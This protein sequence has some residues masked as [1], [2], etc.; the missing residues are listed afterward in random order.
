MKNTLFGH[1]TFSVTPTKAS[2]TQNNKLTYN[3]YF[4]RFLPYLA[5]LGCL[6][7]KILACILDWPVQS[8]ITLCNNNATFIFN[9]VI[10]SY[11]CCSE[12]LPPLFFSF[13]LKHNSLGRRCQIESIITVVRFKSSE[14]RKQ[15]NHRQILSKKILWAS[16][17][18]GS[19]SARA[20]VCV[21]VC[22]CVP[23]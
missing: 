20:V 16:P 15:T 21:C 6:N 3:I 2:G 18:Q 7:H 19:A 8:I 11:S 1:E 17:P 22:V 14:L 5:K 12:Y 4:P 9:C 13:F 10:L 23:T